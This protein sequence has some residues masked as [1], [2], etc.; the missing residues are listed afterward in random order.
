VGEERQKDIVIWS[1]KFN[2][3]TFRV[4]W[5]E[6]EGLIEEGFVNWPGRWC[7]MQL[8][9]ARDLRQWYGQRRAKNTRA[10]F[11]VVIGCCREVD[12]SSFGL[13]FPGNNSVG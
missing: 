13:I 3:G 2:S 8:P 12:E 10:T 6:T 4:P 9:P 5:E 1:P 11:T 7:V